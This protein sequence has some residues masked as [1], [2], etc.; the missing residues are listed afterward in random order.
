MVPQY[1]VILHPSSFYLC[2]ALAFAASAQQWPA[3]PLRIVAPSAAGSAADTLARVV[4]PPLSDR[5][6]QPVIVD[7]RPGAA[8]IIGT[9]IVAKS[10][11]DGH[12]LLIG[13]PA[14]TI[15]PSIYKSLSYDGL[16]DFTA[17]TQGIRQSNL[18]V[19]HPSLPVRSTKELIALAR[20]RPGELVYASAGI[21]AASHLAVELFM[22]QS[23]TKMLHVPYKGPTPGVIDLIAGRVSVMATSTLSTLTH[24]RSGRLRALGITT[25]TRAPLL[26]DIPTVAET[27]LPGYEAVSWFGF[28]AP[29]GTPKEVIARLHKE[30]VAI[31]NQPEIKERFARDG[32]EVVAGSP[33]DFAAYIRS[34]AV[35]WAKVVK[36]AGIKPE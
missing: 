10:P 12:T 28:M 19:V 18:L 23:G 14:L 1:K 15:N 9:E 24:V 31:L 30:I 16:K 36:A 26:P 2:C 6:G 7:T 17:I 35:K 34:E 25:A 11:P 8:T 29:A 3:K 21:G 33:E 13:L 27:G 4:A 32:A 5:L 22:L 20:A